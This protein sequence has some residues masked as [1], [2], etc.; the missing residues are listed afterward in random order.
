M[1]AVVTNHTYQTFSYEEIDYSP[2]AL[3]ARVW[4]QIGQDV[5][6]EYKQDLSNYMDFDTYK[7]YILKQA[8]KRFGTEFAV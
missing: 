3:A 8:N 2:L 6:G 4:P 1:V 5:A 7:T